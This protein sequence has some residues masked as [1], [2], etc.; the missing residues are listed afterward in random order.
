M[1]LETKIIGQD[2]RRIVLSQR[3]PSGEYYHLFTIFEKIDCGMQD[4]EDFKPNFGNEYNDCVK[5]V[6]CDEDKIYLTVDKILM[7]RDLYEQPWKDYYSGKA[8]LKPYKTQYQWPVGKD[9]WRIIPSDDS[10]NDEVK[11]I[12]PHRYSSQYIRYC[13]LGKQDEEDL[14]TVFNN[15]KLKV[16]IAKL[17]ENNLG[18]D[19]T[20][21]SKYWGGFFF[22]L[23]N[24]NYS[25]I[26]F[27]EK[28]THDGIFCRITYKDNHNKQALKLRC[29]RRGD[30]GGV[31]DEKMFVLD[32][33]KSLYDLNLGKRFHSLDLNI[34]DEQDN[35]LDYYC[36]LRFIHSIHFDMRVGDR[37]INVVDN[38]G[39]IIKTVQKYVE[40]DR[41]VIGDKKKI[42]G[43]MDSSPEYSYRKF[44]ESL[45]FVFYDGEKDK[46]E[47]NIAKSDRDIL[48]ILNSARERIYICDAFF[49]VNSL[50]RFVVPM[51]SRIVHIKIITGK[52]ELKADNKR[53]NLARAIRSLNN[54]D[55]ANV[56]CRLLLGKKTALH[57]RYIVADEQ[58]WMLGCS[59][60]QY[61]IR[62]TTLIRVPK[63]YKHKLIDKAEEWWND[64]TLTMDIND[65]KD[66]DQTSKKCFICKWLDKLC[67]R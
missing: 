53:Q 42:E 14:K 58:V 44:E 18:F 51:E 15:A 55:V 41:I 9:D 31:I 49:D 66:N 45:D 8:L 48:R 2:V 13:I 56:E 4:Y 25:K 62:A 52:A 63:D 46:V 23:N 37:A 1:E 35:L 47:D 29:N 27:T 12:L 19:L 57:D 39:H 40:A 36:N 26:S 22:V 38:D 28:D 30:D 7:T 43:L 61:G 59:L 21:H 6:S 34:Y 5:T 65:V 10:Y 50:N 64:G 11:G 60:N 17:T 54:K 16:Q 3:K 67:R 24:D 32:G 33:S 20:E